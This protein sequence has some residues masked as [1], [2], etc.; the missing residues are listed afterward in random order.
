MTSELYNS[1]EQRL[2]TVLGG[3][4]FWAAMQQCRK[5]EGREHC[6]IELQW[7]DEKIDQIKPEVR[8]VDEQKYLLFLLKY[9]R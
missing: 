6:R 7:S 9:T 2:D 1:H 4:D 5:G 3:A 8:V